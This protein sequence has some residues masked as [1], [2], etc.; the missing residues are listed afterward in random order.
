M[1]K[2]RFNLCKY[3]IS[4]EAQEQPRGFG[5]TEH[6]DTT[7]GSV[8]CKQ[9]CALLKYF[10]MF[11]Q[12]SLQPNWIR[13]CYGGLQNKSYLVAHKQTLVCA[14]YFICEVIAALVPS[15]GAV[16]SLFSGQ[17]QEVA[18]G[19]HA[20]QAGVK[21]RVQVLTGIEFLVTEQH[22]WPSHPKPTKVGIL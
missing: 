4:Q 14:Q 15:V 21:D 8:L 11:Q 18:C 12:V 3:T 10:L 19:Q 7:V 1:P 17:Q 2:I 16:C 5:S 22:V 20:L 6:A 13:G 9:T